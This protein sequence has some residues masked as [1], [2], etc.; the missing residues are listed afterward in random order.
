MNARTLCL[1]LGLLFSAFGS[2]KDMQFNTMVV[3]GDS[4][5]DNGNLYRYLWHKLPAS[6]PYYKGRFSNGPVWS[7]NLYQSY[8]GS[9][10]PDGF[11]DFAVGGAGAVLSYK[12]NLPYTLTMELNDYLYWHSHGEKNATLYVIWIGANNYLNGP[13]N[14]ETITTSVVDA[15]SGA[16]E[17]LIS[18]GANK[19]FLGNLPSLDNTPQSREAG[20]QSLLAE[21]TRIHN[22]K[23]KK[24]VLALQDKYPEVTFVYLDVNALLNETMANPGAYGMSNVTEPCY[25]GSYTGWLLPNRVSDENLEAYLAQQDKQFTKKT[26]DMI[27]D[28]PDLKEAAV[29]GY[30][31]TLLPKSDKQEPINCDAY[32]FWDRVHP[33]AKVHELLAEKA[34]QLLDE[35]GIIASK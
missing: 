2:A 23:L 29:V 32:L 7:E 1:F 33:A 31:S 16:V 6:P 25:L 27:K 4:L 19:F 3:L 14:V 21:L 9:S 30:L 12:G 26:W 22:E 20:T 24:A 17:R 5:S 34:R 28:N 11:Q 13:S 15:I 10:N 18:H 8:F 35:S